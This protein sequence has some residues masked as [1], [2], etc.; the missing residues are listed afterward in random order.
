MKMKLLILLLFTAQYTFA[1]KR[2]TEAVIYYDVVI[3]TSN[4]TPQAADMLD[5]STNIIYVKG[6]LNRSDFIS[7]LGSHSTIFDAKDGSAVNI[8]DYGNKKFMITYTPEEWKV[9]NKKYESIT[10]KIE[11]EFKTI[12]GYKCQKAIG[13][14]SDGTTFTVYFTKDLLPLNADFQYI[15]KNLPGLAMQYDATR[16]GTK[17]TFTVSNIEFSTVP[18][19]KFDIPKTG[20]RVMSYTEF[21]KQNPSGK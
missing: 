10:Y 13:K 6:N 18:M 8:R 9:Y 17:V 7:S 16:S 2:L 4:E 11:N 20:Y 5:G 15:N 19:A 3:N 21:R 14:L 1:Q 12:A